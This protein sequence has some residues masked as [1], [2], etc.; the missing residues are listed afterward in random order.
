MLT[1]RGTSVS[2]AGVA[3]WFVAR[4]IGSPGVEVVG[5]G[6]AVLPFFAGLVVRGA[7]RDL[8]VDRRLSDTRIPPGRRVRID[9]HVRNLSTRTAPLLLFEDHLPTTLGRPARLVVSDL[10]GRSDRTVSYTVLPQSR[11]YYGIGPLSIDTTDPFGLARV[12][13]RLGEREELVVL[14]QVEDLT[15]PP[16][17]ASGHNVGA[18]RARQLLRSGEEYYTM[19]AYQQ[20]DDLRRIHWPS[21]ARTGELMI[22]QDEAT[23]RAAGVLFVDNREAAL[24]RSHE[25]AFERTVSSAA[26][27]GMLLANAGFTIRLATSDTPAVMYGGDRFLDALAGLPHTK[28]PSLAT[29]LSNVRASATADTSFVFFGAPPAPQELPTLLRAGGGF[30]PKMAILVHP[31]DPATAPPSRR[32]QLESRA[33]QST[34]A[35]ARAGWDCIL[36]SPSTRLAERWHVPRERRLASNA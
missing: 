26:S 19:R 9:L 5:I 30:G 17:A 16:E 28:I 21:V 14:P 33:T 29:S 13:V 25:P 11:G 12:R 34:L 24:G 35:L 3:T 6:L 36:L 23:K 31:V 27:V 22:R 8:R 15:T 2:L 10:R 18:S 4:L 20:G 32:E 7:R 1:R